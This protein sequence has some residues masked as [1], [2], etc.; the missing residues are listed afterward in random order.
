[1]RGADRK[2]E[3]VQGRDRTPR[4][5]PHKAPCWS[6]H[7]LRRMPMLIRQRLPSEAM[8][9][10]TSQ[11]FHTAGQCPAEGDVGARELRKRSFLAHL[12]AKESEN[13][14]LGF[15]LRELHRTLECS[16]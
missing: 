3:N 7:R 5:Q 6:K 12:P 2:R 8:R 13:M 10:K 15:A 11:S 16:A 1:M 14:Y 9:R 4:L